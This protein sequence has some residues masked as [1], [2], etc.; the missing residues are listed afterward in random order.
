M[1][2]VQNQ[3]PRNTKS[4]PIGWLVCIAGE[5]L[6]KYLSLLCPVE[7]YRERESIS[8][9][10]DEL[11]GDARLIFEPKSAKMT[12]LPGEGRSDMELNQQKVDEAV[13]LVHRD[14]LS[15]GDESYQFI[16][17]CD[18]VHQWDPWNEEAGHEDM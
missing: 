2:T 15:A 9:G 17:F 12:F 10:L 7:D 5:K 18:E 4:L 14:I 3:T 16:A 11:L 1:E 13:E 8:W 6:A